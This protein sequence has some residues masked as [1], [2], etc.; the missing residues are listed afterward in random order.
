MYAGKNVFCQKNVSESSCRQSSGT[1]K[2]QSQL[3]S[4]RNVRTVN[5]GSY[6][7]LLRQNSPYTLDDPYIYLYVYIYIYIYIEREREGK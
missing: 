7:Q 4:L 6:F 2:D 1:W 5:N 3:N